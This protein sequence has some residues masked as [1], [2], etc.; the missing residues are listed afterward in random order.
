MVRT[1]ADIPGYEGLY[2]ITEE[3]IITNLRTNTILT[4]NINSFGYRVVRL[5]KNK[6]AKD[7]KVHQLLAK[8]FIP[9]PN[10]YR[11]VNHIDGN[12][13]NNSLDNLEWCT[14]GQNTIHA[15]KILK[16]DFSRKP[17]VQ[18]TLDGKLIAVWSSAEVAALF[19]KGSA[20][21]IRACCTGTADFA[22]DSKWEY[23]EQ[24]S[25]SQLSEQLST[26]RIS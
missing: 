26:L 2:D 17:V 14:H 9:N 7:F 10:N 3:G 16:L 8:T 13:L 18:T 25:N 4:G 23:V 24:L 19:I 11:C 22:Y 5:S 6:K 12:K 1:M 21:L 20:T 15:R